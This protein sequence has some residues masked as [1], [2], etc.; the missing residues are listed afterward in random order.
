MIDVFMCIIE[1]II[2]YL[3]YIVICN[4]MRGNFNPNPDYMSSNPVVA[5]AIGNAANRHFENSQAVVEAMSPQIYYPSV[6]N[7]SE[8][9]PSTPPRGFPQVTSRSY[10]HD[11]PEN[12]VVWGRN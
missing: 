9:V 5:A 7:Y 8:P 10:M 3:A 6:G 4:K 2:I 12:L 11:S 1:I